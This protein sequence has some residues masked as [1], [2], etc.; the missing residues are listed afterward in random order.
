MSLFKSRGSDREPVQVEH[1]VPPAEPNLA[2]EM[3][4]IEALDAI[5]RALRVLD[6]A[7]LAGLDRRAQD[8]LLDVR[9][10]LV[11]P[12]PQRTAVPVIPG[13]N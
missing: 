9:N 8:V 7:P 10:A 3:R 4:L 6:E 11:P 12:L 13:R 1:T 5:G 2:Q